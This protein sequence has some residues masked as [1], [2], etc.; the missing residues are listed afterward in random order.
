MA[1]PVN[2]AP[3]RSQRDVRTA[4]IFTDEFG[5]Q[6]RCTVNNLGVHAGYP[7]SPLTPLFEAPVYPPPQFLVIDDIALGRIHTNTQAWLE[8]QQLAHD[9]Y[10][11]LK[12]STAVQLFADGAADAIK[13]GD[14]ALLFRIGYP[15]TPIEQVEAYAEGHPWVL[16]FTTKKPKSLAPFFPDPPS[17]P[18]RK[19]LTAE[20]E[21]KEN[22]PTWEED[23]EGQ[24][25]PERKSGG[26]VRPRVGE[27][28][29][30]S[31]QEQLREADEEAD[32]YLREQ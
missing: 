3:I 17:K 4:R 28:R 31:Q 24:P 10:E 19:F 23:E 26:G 32:K 12:Q 6:W 16:G 2:T 21:E 29:R 7:V 9:N 11:L 25:E 20:E 14:K 8:A 30:R 1:Q 15:P 27:P 22:E 18:T 5:R 13:R